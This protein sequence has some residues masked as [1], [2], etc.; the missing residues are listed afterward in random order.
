VKSGWEKFWF[1]SEPYFDLGVLRIA[2]VTLQCLG[3]VADQFEGLM[4]V[5]GLPMSLY[6]PV[7]LV[8]LVTWPFG[9]AHPINTDILF[10]IYWL[11]L[12]CGLGALIGLYTSI[13]MVGLAAGAVFLQ[14]YSYSFV[15]FHHN[16]AV[17]LIALSAL[18]LSPCGKVLSID[19]WIARR[20]A[21]PGTHTIALLDYRGTYAGWS[22]KFVQCLFPLIYLSAAFSKIALSNYSF[23][24]AN[25]YTL[26]YYLLQDSVRKSDMA[27]G[28]WASQF[29]WTILFSQIVVLVY[30]FTYFLVVPFPKLRWIYLPVGL[31]FHYANYYALRAPFPEWILLLA[32][33]V[34]WTEA[35]K[36][37]LNWQ[38][39]VSPAELSAAEP[40]A[41][42]SVL[43]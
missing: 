2:V 40:M 21:A 37:L 32:F 22:I 13:C 24:W 17:L 16:E 18:A 26:Q 8:Q 10:T 43:R 11:T 36:K 5:V 14:T 9:S 23:D 7:G 39:P 20:K 38:V 1:S 6:H 15:D 27:L 41:E 31:F 25:G 34:P 19:S 33:Y 42:K 30:Q 4:H 29:H 12:F 35:A 28:L 3:L